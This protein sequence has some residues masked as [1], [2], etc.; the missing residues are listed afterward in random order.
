MNTNKTLTLFALAAVTTLTVL[1]AA[2]IV[3]NLAGANGLAAL[4]RGAQIPRTPG[5]LGLA[6]IGAAAGALLFMCSDHL[7]AHDDLDAEEY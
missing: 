6:S 7:G 1:G 4:A 5:F 3:A 2:V